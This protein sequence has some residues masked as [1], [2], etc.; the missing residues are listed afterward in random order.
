MNLADHPSSLLPHPFVLIR[1]DTLIAQKVVLEVLVARSLLEAP[2]AVVLFGLL[3]ELLRNFI[4]IDQSFTTPR[5]A[6]PAEVTASCSGF[7]SSRVSNRY[8]YTCP[9]ANSSVNAY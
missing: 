5:Y 1:L 8:L 6:Q 9:G 4:A 7:F 2:Y 3:L